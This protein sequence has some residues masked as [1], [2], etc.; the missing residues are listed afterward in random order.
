MVLAGLI[1]WLVW[2]DGLING[3]ASFLVWNFSKTDLIKRPGKWAGLKKVKDWSS[4]QKI[5][6]IEL[7]YVF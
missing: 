3:P 2:D 5:P 6:K 4:A 1:N 7:K